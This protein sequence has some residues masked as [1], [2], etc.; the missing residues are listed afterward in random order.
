MQR[1][2]AA[3]VSVASGYTHEQSE[4]VRFVAWFQEG[5]GLLSVGKP[6]RPPKS[7]NNGENNFPRLQSLKP[8]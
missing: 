4:A 2:F 6:L 3:S 5:N 7:G 1:V 8:R